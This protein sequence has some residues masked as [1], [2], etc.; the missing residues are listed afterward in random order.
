[1]STAERFW[2][3][4]ATDASYKVAFLNALPEQP[5]PQDLAQFA[6][7]TGFE[8][9]ATEILQHARD[10]LLRA[11]TVDDNERDIEG[12]RVLHLL[13]Y[14][15]TQLVDVLGGA[16][17]EQFVVH[18]KKYAGWRRTIVESPLDVDHRLLDEICGRTLNGRVLSY[19]LPELTDIP[20][21]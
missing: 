3:K 20:V 5:T 9:S 8:L 1:M 7:D 2:D 10:S 4:I 12:H 18:L 6:G 13:D 15:G 11:S 19:P 21:L 17:E 16:F 14:Q